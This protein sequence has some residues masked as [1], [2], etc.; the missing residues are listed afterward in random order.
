[1][2]KKQIKSKKIIS[3]QPSGLS[4][5]AFVI[6]LVGFLFSWFIFIGWLLNLLAIIFASVSLRQDKNKGLSIVALILGIIGLAVWLL[7]L[8]FS[9]FFVGTMF[10][11]LRIS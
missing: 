8:I 10:Q 2:V 7:A 1:M 5:A 6:S 4:I 3:E 11:M 9:S